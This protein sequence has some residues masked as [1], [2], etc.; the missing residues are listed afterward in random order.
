MHETYLIVVQEVCEKALAKELIGFIAQLHRLV[1]FWTRFS[2]FAC[3]RTHF[4]SR[5]CLLSINNTGRRVR[6]L[7]LYQS[8]RQDIDLTFWLITFLSRLEC[9]ALCKWNVLVLG[10]L[11]P[12]LDTAAQNRSAGRGSPAGPRRPWSV[13]CITMGKI[14]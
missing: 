11:T 10:T 9:V 14:R 4:F 13:Y 8:N 12:V 7:N 6:A 3:F 2:C 1:C 5:F